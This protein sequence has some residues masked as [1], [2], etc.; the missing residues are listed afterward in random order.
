MKKNLKSDEKRKKKKKKGA[1]LI[2]IPG[3]TKY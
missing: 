2:N 3:G 1:P